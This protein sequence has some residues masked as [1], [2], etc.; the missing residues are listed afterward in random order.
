MSTLLSHHRTL[1]QCLVGRGQRRSFSRDL[2]AVIKSTHQSSNESFH[3]S[4]NSTGVKAALIVVFKNVFHQKLKMCDNLLVSRT[5]IS[6]HHTNL[7]GD[8]DLEI[9]LL[10]DFL[11]DRLPLRLFLRLLCSRTGHKVENFIRQLKL[12]RLGGC[13]IKV[14]IYF[15]STSDQI[16]VNLC[17]T[18]RLPLRDLLAVL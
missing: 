5:N 10:G 8:G 14:C 7:R 15:Q 13:G 2:G 11:G 4:P 18:H 16:H 1:Y 3:A 12:R 9:L 17:C 6:H